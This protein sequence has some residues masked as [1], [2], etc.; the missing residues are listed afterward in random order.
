[1]PVR[2]ITGFAFKLVGI[3]H[4]TLLGTIT[5]P[6]HW[7]EILHERKSVEFAKVDAP[8]FGWMTESANSEPLQ[9]KVGCLQ[10]SYEHRDGLYLH[11]LSIEEFET[12]E[13]CSFSPSAA[14]L[15]SII[16]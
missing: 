5:I 10:Q 2:E 15:R 13:G 4:G 16:E 9:Y 7:V 14:Y 1:M 3:H 6:G 12:M 8:K 11:G